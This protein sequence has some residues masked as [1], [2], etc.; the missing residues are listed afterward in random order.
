[1]NERNEGQMNQW[2]K[3]IKDKLTNELINNERNDD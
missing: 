1:M 3:G 2:M